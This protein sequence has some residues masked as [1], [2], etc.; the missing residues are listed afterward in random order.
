MISRVFGRHRV[1][2][3]EVLAQESLPTEISPQLPGFRA[4]MLQYF[5]REQTVLGRR[6]W[7][8]SLVQGRSLHPHP[9]P[10][11]VLVVHC[12]LQRLVVGEPIPSRLMETVSDPLLSVCVSVCS[13]G[14]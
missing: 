4:F 6:S 7:E 10:P 2:R 1:V 9:S 12:A 14:M 5:D 8:S 13:L 3:G 11:R